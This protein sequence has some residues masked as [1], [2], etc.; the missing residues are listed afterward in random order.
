MIVCIDV[1]GLKSSFVY[2]S[3]MMAVSCNG[4]TE[5]AYIGYNEGRFES[6]L[7]PYIIW[8]AE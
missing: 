3:G 4:E 5:V 2:S 6:I 1:L 8:A 7:K